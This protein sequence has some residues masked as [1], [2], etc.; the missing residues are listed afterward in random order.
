VRSV[1]ER[2]APVPVYAI[3]GITVSR[4]PAVRRAGAHGVAACAAFLR[5]GDPR[6]VAEA[7]VLALDV[8]R[9]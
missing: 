8:A 9:A 4:V 3:G 2:I 1:V 7:M 5:A 6:R